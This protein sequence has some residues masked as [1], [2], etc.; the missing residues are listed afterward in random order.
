MK[1]R[2]I[3]EGK[4][5]TFSNLLTVVRI[6]GGPIMAY[7]IYKEHVTGDQVFLTYQLICLVIIVISDFFDGFLARLMNQVTK[8]G[9]FLDPLADKFAGLI[10]LTFIMLYKGFP[11]WFYI[12]ALS[13]EL[14]FVIVS[15]IIYLR[16]D[17]EAK[18]NVFGKF[19][20]AGLAFSALLYIMAID[21]SFRG[22][23]LKEFS[24]FLVILFYILG[25][26]L[27]T[28]TFIR[29]YREKKA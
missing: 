17:F 24:I 25:W 27:Y 3:F 20:T 19:S 10:T 18:P 23:T 2:E 13:R 4:I 26:I 21:Y 12:V 15:I 5:V 14:I 11:L 1:I 22:I 28:K 16:V 9:Q 6:I 29:Y 7:L 8:L